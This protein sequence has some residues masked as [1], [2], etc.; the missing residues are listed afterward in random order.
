MPELF[1]I[2]GEKGVGREGEKMHIIMSSDFLSLKVGKGFD[3]GFQP[4]QV[5]SNLLI[6]SSSTT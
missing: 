4:F 2:I 3:N 1:N 6:G 5:R